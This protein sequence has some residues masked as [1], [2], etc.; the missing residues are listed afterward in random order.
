MKFLLI[1]HF[2]LC[3]CVSKLLETQRHREHGGGLFYRETACQ[4]KSHE[5]ALS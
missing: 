4:G 3:L 1:P 2:S 5:A